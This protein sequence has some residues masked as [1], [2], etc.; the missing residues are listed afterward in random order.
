MKQS[1]VLIV[2]LLA[3]WKLF[4]PVSMASVSAILSTGLQLFRNCYF[5]VNTQTI[6]L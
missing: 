5:L 4:F 2:F 1:K 3:S 6:L